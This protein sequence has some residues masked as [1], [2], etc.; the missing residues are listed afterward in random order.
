MTLNIRQV[1]S[2]ESGTVTGICTLECTLTHTHTHTNRTY[3]HTRTILGQGLR[4]MDLATNCNLCCRARIEI[5]ARLWRPPHILATLKIPT[6][7]MR[8]LYARTHARI[9]HASARADA[10]LCAAN[11]LTRLSHYEKPERSYSSRRSAAT[12]DAHSHS[13][14]RNRPPSRCRRTRS[15]HTRTRRTQCRI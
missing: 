15:T 1:N 12:L 11:K 10:L 3:T 6:V 8:A 2:G 4:H 9:C 13:H 7:R 5:D 14:K